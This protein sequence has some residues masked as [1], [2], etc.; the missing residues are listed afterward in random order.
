MV[1]ALF[2][3]MKKKLPEQCPSCHLPVIKRSGEKKKK[4]NFRHNLIMDAVSPLFLTNFEKLSKSLVT[5][6][7]FPSVN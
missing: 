6:V 7:F 3:Q 1:P 5:T 2:L 4:K